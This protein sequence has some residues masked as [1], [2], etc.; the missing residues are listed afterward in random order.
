[1]SCIVTKRSD[2]QLLIC[3]ALKTLIEPLK[4]FVWPSESLALGSP[5]D[6]IIVV[7]VPCMPIER[8]F[9]QFLVY[10]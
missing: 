5:V 1:M 10:A 4:E 8:S 3:G 9:S 6:V 7:F 2:V